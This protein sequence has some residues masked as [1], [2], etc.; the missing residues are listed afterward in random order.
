MFKKEH[1]SHI[2]YYIILGTI[3]FLGFLAA[4]RVKEIFLLLPASYAVIAILHHALL[5]TLTAKIVVEY[6]LV[7]LLGTAVFLML[8]L[9]G[10]I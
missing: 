2:V 1:H 9:T 4:W 3:L 10:S 6:V 7:A 8:L 5:H